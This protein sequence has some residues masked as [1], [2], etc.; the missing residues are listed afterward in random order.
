[1]SVGFSIYVAYFWQ[2]ETQN[3]VKCS[4]NFLFEQKISI[5]LKLEFVEFDDALK[6]QSILKQ[7]MWAIYLK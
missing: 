2:S 3:E 7:T 6:K 4:I 5:C 1:M